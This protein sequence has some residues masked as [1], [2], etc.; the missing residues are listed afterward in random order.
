[1]DSRLKPT[2]S[3]DE[4]GKV[5]KKYCDKVF[6]KHLTKALKTNLGEP[7]FLDKIRG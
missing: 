1:M 3:I 6:K 2:T 7:G 4:Q 5:K